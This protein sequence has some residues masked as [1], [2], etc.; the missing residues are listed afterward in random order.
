MEVSRRDLVKNAGML[1]VG[2]GFAGLS[3]SMAKDA[4]GAAAGKQNS[5]PD[6]PWPYKKLNPTHAAEIAHAAYY[7]G[8]CCYGT[9]EGIVGPLRK[10]IGFPYTMLPSTLFLVGE[11][12]VAGTANLC[13]TMNGAASAVFLVTG[14]MDK[15]RKEAAY[16]II[17]DVYDWYERTALPLYQPKHPKF[18]IVK[19][20]SKSTICHVSVSEWCKASG[21]KAFSKERAER[22]ARL[23]ATVA[24]HTVEALNSYADGTFKRAYPLTAATQ[25]CR[26]CHDKGGELENTRSMMEC[27]GCHFTLK[28]KHPA[29]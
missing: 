8:A 19:S 13:G 4:I 15:K 17:R 3:L 6:L 5:L 26:G 22:C 16:S 18:E 11:G 1:V 9:F 29:I 27:D 14:G 21:F 24:R 7:K 28:P 20:T 25:T 2:T 23:A 10:K 12:G